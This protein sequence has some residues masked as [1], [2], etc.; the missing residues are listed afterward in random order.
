MGVTGNMGMGTDSS[1]SGKEIPSPE[2]LAK[3]GLLVAGISHNLYGPLTGIMGTLDLLK[4][5]H[6]D[7]AKDLERVSGLARRLQDEIRVML[8]KAEIEYRGSVVM[9]EM[10][11]LVEGEIEFYKGDPRFKHMTEITFEPPENLPS[12]RASAGDFTQ[13]ISNIFAN[14]I[15]AMEESEKKEL[16]IAIVEEGDNLV[17]TIADTGIGMDEETLAHAFDPFFTTKTPTAG[18]KF[19]ATLAQGLGLTHAKNMLDSAGVAIDLASKQGEGTT[20]TMT[21]PYKDI[22]SRHAASL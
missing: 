3:I 10:A 15:E 22:D 11:K 13:S 9:I 16:T 4:M 2:K 19:P 20:V 7:L 18:G 8:H 21:I 17:L 5:K 1:S 12:F 6:P 14:A